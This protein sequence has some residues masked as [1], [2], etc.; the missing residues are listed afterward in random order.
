MYNT[1]VDVKQFS[2]TIP[3]SF[4]RFWLRL[5]IKIIYI[6]SFDSTIGDDNFDFF[7]FVFQLR[8]EMYMQI[9]NKIKFEILKA[10]NK[11]THWDFYK[12]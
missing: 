5:N 9:I 1:I 10:N 3:V 2:I 11:F 6:N 4:I 7:T 8:K 12:G